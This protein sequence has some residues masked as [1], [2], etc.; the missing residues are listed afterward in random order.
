M[1]RDCHF[2]KACRLV[3]EAGAVKVVAVCSHPL[4]VAGAYERMKEA[5][6]PAQPQPA[7]PETK[8]R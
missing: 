8:L 5:S 4:L 7:S 2:K 1:G 6:T 3:K